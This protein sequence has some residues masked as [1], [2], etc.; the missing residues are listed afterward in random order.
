MH[1]VA[2]F[3]AAP[4]HRHGRTS[5]AG[6]ETVARSQSNRIP[7]QCQVPVAGGLSRF[8]ARPHAYVRVH[9]AL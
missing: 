9:T 4:D 5:P 7:G 8:T 3:A 1:V 6:T 2:R